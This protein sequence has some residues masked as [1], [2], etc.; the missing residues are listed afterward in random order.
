VEDAYPNAHV[1]LYPFEDE[2]VFYPARAVDNVSAQTDRTTPVD[3]LLSGSFGT[4]TQT[5][6]QVVQGSGEWRDGKWR[7]LFARDLTMDG[8]YAQFAEEERTNVAFAVWD[9]ERSERDGTKSVSQFLTLEV[10]PEVAED[11]G[12]VTT[13]IIVL[14][15]LGAVAMTLVLALYGRQ[16]RGA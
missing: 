8:D 12:N 13:W 1:D 15:A 4:L 3:N 2:A 11:G 7:V 9:G 6:D 10:S 14:V 16:R 5:P